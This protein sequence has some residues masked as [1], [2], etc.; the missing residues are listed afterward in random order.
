MSDFFFIFSSSLRLDLKGDVLCPVPMYLKCF[1]ENSG[2]GLATMKIN[3]Y[4]V[5]S[6]CTGLGYSSEGETTP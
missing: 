1:A 6:M 4:R 5:P 3:M 2:P